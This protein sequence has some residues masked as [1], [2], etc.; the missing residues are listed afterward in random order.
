[1][2]P[3][4]LLFRAKTYEIPVLV[5][6]P[7]GHHDAARKVLKDVRSLVEIVAPEDLEKRVLEAPEVK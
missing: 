1:M 7:T 5:V 2:K 4:D 3:L 6:V